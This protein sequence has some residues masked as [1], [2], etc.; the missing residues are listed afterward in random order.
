MERTT[1]WQDVEIGE[2]VCR[3]GDHVSE[4]PFYGICIHKRTV[5]PWVDSI[6]LVRDAVIW[7]WRGY[8]LLVVG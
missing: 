8:L 3:G 7:R 5:S 6:H 4:L 1:S 2:L